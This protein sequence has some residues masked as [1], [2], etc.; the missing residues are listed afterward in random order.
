MYF[1]NVGN[2]THFHIFQ[3]PK[4]RIT[5][6]NKARKTVWELTLEYRVGD[7]EDRRTDMSF[8]NLCKDVQY[9]IWQKLVLISHVAVDTATHP[10][11]LNYLEFSKICGNI[12]TGRKTWVN[13]IP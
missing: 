8:S 2:I 13:F 7:R 12:C 11:S 5:V 6:S 10:M 4:S 3:R 9:K 1:R